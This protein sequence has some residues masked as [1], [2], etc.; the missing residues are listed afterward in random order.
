MTKSMSFQYNGSWYK[1]SKSIN[2]VYTFMCNGS[3]I[4]RS[5]FS[6]AYKE[7]LKH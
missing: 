1:I 3:S 6:N 7:H 5:T 2:N 4:D